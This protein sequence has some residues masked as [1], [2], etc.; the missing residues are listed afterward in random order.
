MGEAGA[1]DSS[2]A[3]CGFAFMFGR[4]V[5][6]SADSAGGGGC[7]GFLMVAELLAFVALGGLVVWVYFTWQRLLKRWMIV[8]LRDSTLLGSETMM[9]LD[10]RGVM[11]LGW[12]ATVV[13]A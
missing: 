8:S 6:V 3:F 12:T 9:E 4:E 11:S 2:C 5:G 7:A 10:P 1:A 13:V